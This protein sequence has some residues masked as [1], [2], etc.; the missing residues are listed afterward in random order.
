MASNANGAD[1]LLLVDLVTV[2]L[3]GHLSAC[4]LHTTDPELLLRLRHPRCQLRWHQHH[5]P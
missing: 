3:N 1:T 4:K 5:Q 2:D